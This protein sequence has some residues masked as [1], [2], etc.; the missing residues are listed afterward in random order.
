MKCEDCKWAEL[1]EHPK[2]FPIK[3]AMAELTNRN[4][5]LVPYF[6]TGEGIRLQNLDSKILDNVV[7]EFLQKD[8]L[9]LLLHDEVICRK[10]VKEEVYVAMREAYKDVLGTYE[11]CKVELK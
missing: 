10:S 4:G 9:V 3:Y 2:A 6:H 5:Y 7:A 11:N 8:E 1:H